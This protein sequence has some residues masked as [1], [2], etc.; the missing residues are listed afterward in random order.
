MPSTIVQ[1]IVPVFSVVAIGMMSGLMLATGLAGYA[2][3][4]LPETSW[5]LR[6]QREDALFA[7]VMPPFF[8]TAL[9]TLGWSSFLSTGTSRSLFA[10]AALLTVVI[11]AITLALQVPINKTVQS[12]T[13]GS[14]PA[15]WP[16]LR[17][18]WLR[19]HLVRTIVTITAFVC[20]VIAIV[21][22]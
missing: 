6:F 12:W 9:I 16:A 8:L 2:D 19:N 11:I 1:F 10:A 7:K 20:A 14:A 13:A 15:H 3:R 22:F 17:D 18:R 5:T 21:H 4:A